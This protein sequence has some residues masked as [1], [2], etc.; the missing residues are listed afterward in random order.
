MPLRLPPKDIG[1]FLFRISQNVAGAQALKEI[2]ANMAVAGTVTEDWDGWDL[3]ACTGF[4][5]HPQVRYLVNRYEIENQAIIA[6]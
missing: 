5:V 6:D 3:A 1:Y 4:K 2:M